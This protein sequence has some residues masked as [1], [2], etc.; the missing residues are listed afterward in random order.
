MSD[1]HLMI[2]I[3]AIQD[4]LYRISLQCSSAAYVIETVSPFQ[5]E[6]LYEQLS[7]LN[8]DRSHLT[9]EK[10]TA[11]GQKLFRFLIGGHADIASAYQRALERVGNQ[12]VFLWLTSESGGRFAA[13]PWEYMHDGVTG[14]LALSRQTP[15]IRRKPELS[16]RPPAPMLSPLK[17][18]VVMAAPPN[19][20]AVQVEDEWECLHHAT[21]HLQLSGQLRLERL[22]HATWPA[23]RRR[24]RAEDYHVL[25]YV[26]YTRYDEPT[27]EGFLALED[28][29][30]ASGSRPLSAA[31]LGSEMGTQST[32]RLVVVNARYHSSTDSKTL[33]TAAGQ[34]LQAGIPAVLTRPVWNGETESY[35][36]AE[37]YR[38]LSEAHPVE[39]ALNVARRAIAGETHS[40]GTTALHL[41]TAN[42]ELF[43]SVRMHTS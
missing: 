11:F 27:Q 13:V 21:L 34:L 39:A 12:R 37:F 30:Y 18:L 43:R 28:E 2:A 4:D 20:P 23:L 3:S 1:E 38:P 35:F 25:H 15:I 41:R 31:E 24:L 26:G 29:R 42:G 36:D 5:K 10:V 16:L 8:R 32:V 19:Y 9:S 40:W 17:V 7:F 33:L 14:F 6:E 22:P